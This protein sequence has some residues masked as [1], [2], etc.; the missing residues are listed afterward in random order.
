[1]VS[2]VSS[3]DG[4]LRQVVTLGRPPTFSRQ[5]E[6]R[7]IGSS[8]TE[9]DVSGGSWRRLLVEGPRLVTGCGCGIA[10]FAAVGE[11]ASHDGSSLAESLL[12]AAGR[13]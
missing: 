6:N 5:P 9:S 12:I 2:A 11:L 13:P 7:G 8:A 1:M 3:G 10:L 4:G